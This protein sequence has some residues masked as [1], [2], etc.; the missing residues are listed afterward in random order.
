[1]QRDRLLPRPGDDLTLGELG[2]QLGEALHRLAVKGGQHQLA[3][4]EVWRL[5]EQDHRVGA[6]DRLE[7]P[8]ALSGMQHV[9]GRLEDLLDVLWVRQ[10]HKRRL[11]EDTD[12]E[13][14]AVALTRAQQPGRG[15]CPGR[16]GL[17]RRRYFGARRELILEAALGQ[18]GLHDDSSCER[19]RDG[20]RGSDLTSSG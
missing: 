20:A 13:A 16:D 5:V 19:W 17:Q 7:D 2:H 11:A 4:F 18:H 3:L 1:M 6:D 9:G 10:D 8:R 12:R 15:A 14:L